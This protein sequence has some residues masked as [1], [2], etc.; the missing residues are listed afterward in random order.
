MIECNLR[1]IDE[2]VGIS[3]VKKRFGRYHGSSFWNIPGYGNACWVVAVYIDLDFESLSADATDQEVLDG[4][5][6]YLN[7]P[8]PRRKYQK[9]KPQPLYGLLE[10][11]QGKIIEHSGGKCLSA[12]LITRQRKNRK[13]WSEGKNVPKTK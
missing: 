12:L 11:Y 2:Y 6:E 8:P 7:V 13:F 9:K 3:S 10:P 5:V 4:C 1:E